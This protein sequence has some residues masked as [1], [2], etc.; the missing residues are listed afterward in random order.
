VN[1]K[2][3]KL[4]NEYIYFDLMPFVNPL[5]I[6]IVDFYKFGACILI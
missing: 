3:R 4:G 2:I 5:A 1:E 6:L